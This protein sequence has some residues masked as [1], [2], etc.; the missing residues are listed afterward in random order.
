MEAAYNRRKEKAGYA[1]NNRFCR[2]S[3]AWKISD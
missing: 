2:N 1:G 3:P